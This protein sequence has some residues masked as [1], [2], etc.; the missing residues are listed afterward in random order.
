MG[1][2]DPTRIAEVYTD[3]WEGRGEVD[4]EVFF[5]V[6]GEAVEAVDSENLPYV[7]MGGMVSRA[8]GRPRDTHDID[9]LVRPDDAHDVLH[10]LESAGFATQ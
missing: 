8:A 9:L 1:E 5:R 10:C 7:L 3:V 2:E 6:L 4:D